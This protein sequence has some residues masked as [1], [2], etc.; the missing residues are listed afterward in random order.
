[1]A[2][3]EKS[4]VLGQPDNCLPQIIQK[5]YILCSAHPHLVVSPPP[6]K[7]WGLQPARVSDGSE[8]LDA[9]SEPFLAG[10]GEIKSNQMLKDTTFL[11][12]DNDF[13]SLPW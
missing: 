12:L 3:I 7:A 13:I 4:T 1:M 5:S 8:T 6:A 2:S 11:R 10:S 9:L